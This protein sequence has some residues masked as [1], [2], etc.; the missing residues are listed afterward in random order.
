MEEKVK[1]LLSSLI[2]LKKS[3]LSTYKGRVG[4]ENM[5][6]TCYLN[7]ALQCL[8][9]TPPLIK[10]VLSSEFDKYKK[11]PGCASAL[12]DLVKDFADCTSSYE[13]K[14]PYDLRY[15]I[16]RL[17]PQFKDYDQQDSFEL[18]ALLMDALNNETNRVV[19]KAEYKMLKQ[20]SATDSELVRQN[21]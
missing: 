11:S 6:N 14:R 7:S 16:G 2:D 18:L 9:H 15:E 20:D 10:H 12:Y 3:S 5:G 21:I 8:L 4:L 17:H 19:H 13:S 1:A